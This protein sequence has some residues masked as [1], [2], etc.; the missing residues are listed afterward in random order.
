MQAPATALRFDISDLDPLSI[1]K[2]KAEPLARLRQVQ[3]QLTIREGYPPTNRANDSE[4]AP[5][6]NPEGSRMKQLRVRKLL[7]LLTIRDS[8]FWAPDKANRE[9]P[10]Q[11]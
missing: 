3:L 5:K 6:N 2:A 10:I 9:Q 8:P 7:K 11:R 1:I 4:M